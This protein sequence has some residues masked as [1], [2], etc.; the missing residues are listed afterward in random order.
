VTDRLSLSFADVAALEKEHER[1]LSRGEARVPDVSGL[2]AFMPCEL[3]IHHPHGGEPLIVKATVMTSPEDQEREGHVRLMLDDVSGAVLT[4]FVA[5]EAATPLDVDALPVPD[6]DDEDD[7]SEDAGSDTPEG[8]KASLPPP[9]RLRALTHPEQVKLARTSRS[10]TER[11]ALER[12]LGKDGWEA[13][14]KNPFLTVPEVARIARKGTVPRPLIE[15]IVN[16]QSWA[17]VAIIRRALLTNP[18]LTPEMITKILR[19]APSHEL[20]LILKQTAYP[21]TVRAAAERLFGRG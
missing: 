15:Q 2:A 16:N 18:K 12:I 19:L 7:D 9:Q 5:R 14:L 17:R 6:F 20:K 1:R 10:L 13:L 4:A 21:P 11:T 3:A 8:A